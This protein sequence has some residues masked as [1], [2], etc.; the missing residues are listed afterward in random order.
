MDIRYWTRPQILQSEESDLANSLPK[1][2]IR[3]WSL[4]CGKLN[5]W[6]TRP[7]TDARY[8][9]Y[10]K[11]HLTRPIFH[12]PSSKCTRIGKRASDSLP[13]CPYISL[14]FLLRVFL[15]GKVGESVSLCFHPTMG[16]LVP[17]RMGVRD[18]WKIRTTMIKSHESL[19]LTHWLRQ[20]DA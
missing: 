11:F 8:I 3:A 20:S 16:I 14:I 2:T 7:K 18:V 17:S 15:V 10:T 19:Y 12:S 6:S 13:D 4:Q 9:F 5:F 1:S